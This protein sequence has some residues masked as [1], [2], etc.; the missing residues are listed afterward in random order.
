MILALGW[1]LLVIGT[2]TYVISL[3]NRSLSILWVQILAIGIG[4]LGFAILK[5]NG[6]L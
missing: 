4:I 1:I 6:A 3:A 2:A 5:A